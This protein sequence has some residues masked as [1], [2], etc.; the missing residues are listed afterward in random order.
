MANPAHLAILVNRR[1]FVFSGG[2]AAVAAQ[3]DVRGRKG[4]SMIIPRA[5]RVELPIPITYRR[6][7]DDH[8]FQARVVNLSE[9]GVLFGPSELEPGTPVEV[10]LSLPIQVGSLATGR[11][12]CAAEV[13][14]ATDIGA[15]A[16]RFEECRFLLDA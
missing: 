5:Q 7:N 2:G 15:V 14:R 16:A 9:S 1:A 6:T 8:W 11:Q 10:M 12:V 3:S 13:V 4:A